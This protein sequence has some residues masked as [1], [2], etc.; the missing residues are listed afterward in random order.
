MLSSRH[1]LIGVVPP[2][3]SSCSSSVGSRYYLWSIR[4][5][6]L[7]LA[8][9]LRQHRLVSSWAVGRTP[10][11]LMILFWR[12]IGGVS[13]SEQTVPMPRRSRHVCPSPF[14]IYGGSSQAPS[15]PSFPPSLPPSRRRRRGCHA[16]IIGRA[17]K[18]ESPAPRESS[19][20]IRCANCGRASY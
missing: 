10:V 13:S 17:A 2:G 5:T 18:G 20:S 1:A 7:S 16:A 12:S 14:T 19:Q 11:I 3:V 4:L 8:A 6:H 9:P 15:S